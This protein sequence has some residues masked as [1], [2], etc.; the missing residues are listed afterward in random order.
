VRALVLAAILAAAPHAPRAAAP[1]PGPG[2]DP[3]EQRREAVAKELV[4]LGAELRR[5]IVAQDVDGIVARVPAGGLRCAGRVVPRAK[6]ARDL[7]SPGSWLH[8]VFFGG[9][10]YETRQGAPRS[11][12]E[13]LR[14]GNEIAILVSFQPDARA[15][16]AGR[17]CID[18]RAKDV[19]TPG[20]PLCFEHRDG[21]WWFTE[22]LYPCG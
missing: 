1:G 9:P 14:T 22:S 3:V 8:D 17:P 18:F 10:A 5:Q 11:V 19:V 12:S 6:V 15:G 7:R 2:V 21:R 4:R 16:P 20:A 13:L